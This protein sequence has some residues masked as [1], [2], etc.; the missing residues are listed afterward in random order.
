VLLLRWNADRRYELAPIDPETGEDLPGYAPMA[1]GSAGTAFAPSVL[2]LSA[3]GRWLAVN[4]PRGQSCEPSAGG[5]SCRGGA[6]VLHLIDLQAWRDGAAGLPAAP[7][8]GWVGPSTFSPG[9]G[10]LA[11][12]LNEQRATTLVLVAT[13][14]GEVVAQRTLA[15][16]FRPALLT[17]VG[18]GGDGASLAL[19]GQPLG[20]DPGMTEPD[21][22]RV[23]LVDAQTLEGQWEHTLA[24]VL[25]GHWCLDNC[26]AA[27]EQRRFA[28]WTPAAQFSPDG[29]ALY[30]VHA[31]EE[32]LTTVDLEARS[33]RTV[34]IEPREEARSW[35]ERLLASILAFGAATASA[36]AGEEGT[37]KAAALSPDGTRLYVLG[38][39]MTSTRDAQGHWETA[40]A[41]TGLQVV[42]PQS[43]RLLA[44]AESGGAAVRVTPDGAY[45]L[46][47]GWEQGQ[48]W[49]EA[50][51]AQSL[52]VV[53]HLAGWKAMATR[54]LG[55]LPAAVASQFGRQAT[56]LAILD[57]R[58]FDVVRSWSVPNFASWVATP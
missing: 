35:P 55:G 32:R 20:A 49:T 2:G 5:M 3:D 1:L 53:A 25:S 47:G 45:L 42:E 41:S 16:G 4:E 31:G 28:S 33:V 50:R 12:T 44:R 17:F 13:E 51:D 43:G 18:S 8:Q 15:P 9:G 22:P 21:P 36:K 39:T 7:S 29:R 26:A 40:E 11:L 34:A 48:P 54:R 37:S 30:V 56:H 46:V 27:H 57:D 24:G 14:S 19:Y 38:R 23:L 52:E 10:R 6:G 58:S